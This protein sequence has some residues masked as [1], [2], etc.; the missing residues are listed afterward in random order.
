MPLIR[1]LVLGLAALSV[2]CGTPRANPVSDAWVLADVTLIDGTGAPARPGVSIVVRDGII[3]AILAAGEPLPA[4][5]STID[6]GGRFVMPGLIDSHVHL[7]TQPRPD[8]MIEQVLNAALLGGVTTVR[9]MGGAGEA[10]RTLAAAE[11]SG[12]ATPRIVFSQLVTGPGSEFWLEGERAAYISGGAAPGTVFGFRRILDPTEVDAVIA[13]AVLNGATGIKLH[14]GFTVGLAG[15][16]VE[17]ARR[18]GLRVWA[19]GEL[20]SAGPDDLAALGVD[21]LSHADMLAYTGVDRAALPSEGYGRRTLSAMALTPVD[22]P[23]LGALLGAMRTNGVALDPTL[24]V[25]GDDEEGAAYRDWVARATRR[26]FAAGVM[27]VAGTDALGGSSPNLHLELQL[28]VSRCGLSPLEAIRAATLNA[29]VVMGLDR[30]L[31][32]VAPGKRADLVVLSADPSVDIRNTLT[33]SAVIKG[34]V[35][36]RRD[37]PLTTPPRAQS[38]QA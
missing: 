14:S 7:K 1:L 3:E 17:A 9:D 30:E 27:I 36:H 38:P 26:A 21:S 25:M 22:G 5:I 24:M 10:I 33:V 15:T 6:L 28:L 13:E 12:A 34:G 4:G 2:G 32:S 35:I 31:G 37:R 29:A 8:G 23:A 18:R 11:R 16:V 20:G 19:H